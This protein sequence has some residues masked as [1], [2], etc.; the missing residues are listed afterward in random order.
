M[1]R[2]PLL[3]F[4]ADF[5]R[6]L[7]YRRYL[8]VEDRFRRLTAQGFSLLTLLLGGTYIV[9]LAQIVRHTRG[10]QDLLFFAAELLAYLLLAILAFDLWQVRY[11]QPDGLKSRQ[12]WTVDL[13]VPCCGE[14][15]EVI[16][17]TLLAV[18]RIPY[19]P[20]TVY[21]LDDGASPA[22]AALAE[23]LGFHYYS[24]PLAGVPKEN[25]KGGN[26]NFGLGLSRGELIL[27]LDADQ[28]PAPDL[29]SRLV[30][31]FHLP[32]VAYVQTKQSFWLPEG[33][34]FFN[35]DE[36][37]YDTVQAG[38]DQ[39]NA[40]ISCGSG[41]LYRRQ[42][43]EE[44]GGFAT[45]NLVEDFTTSYELLS[46]GWKGLYFPYA[47][48]RG[49]A[50]MTL[51]GV[52]RQRYQWCLD[53]MRLF[54]WDNPLLKKG[55]S[56]KQSL[57]FLLIMMSYVVSGLALPAFYIS[58]LLCYWRGY[59]C[60]QGQEAGYLALRGAYLI[61]TIMMF[62]YLFYRK[63]S[64]KQFKML[65]ALFPAYIVAILAALWYPPGRKPRYR[66]NNCR[67]WGECRRWWYFSPYLG[68]IL[69]HTGMPFL[70]LNL[71]WASPQI[72][73][74]NALFSA[75]IIWVLADLMVAGVSKLQ[76]PPSMDPRRVYGS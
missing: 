74:F 12:D 67:P 43:L 18:S 62:R 26:L 50:P 11:H 72:I 57:H 55:L 63:N 6:L 16:R 69:L 15:L 7:P 34:P 76:W 47:L 42:A 39:G 37:F 56:W 17:T 61:A 9:W 60:L 8:D 13:F 38:N 45:W 52:Y 58:P 51:A 75:F 31:F 46:R 24:R 4:W 54:F 14:P 36:I 59:S 66:V 48:S 71:G 64:L 40:V 65:C 70:S 41:V 21:V 29:V 25:G 3:F 22:V 35:S 20:L 5:W 27:V 10:V 30:G 68:V 23:S 32:R 1:S 73:L 49:L 19:R 33:D 53:T 28:V 44:L 2:N